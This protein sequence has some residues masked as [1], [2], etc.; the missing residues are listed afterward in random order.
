MA[1]PTEVN[2]DAAVC[3]EINDAVVAEVGKVRVSQKVF[4]TT[5][6][7]NDPTEVT[8]IPSRLATSASRKA[9]PKPSLKFLAL[10]RNL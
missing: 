7:D 8:T 9:E 6:F 2:W 4:R 5:V 10:S 1:N 3:K